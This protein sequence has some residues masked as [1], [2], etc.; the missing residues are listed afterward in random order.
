MAVKDFGK[1]KFATIPP[2]VM[3]IIDVN[4]PHC[5]KCFR[6]VTRWFTIWRVDLACYLR[7][8]LGECWDAEQVRSVFVEEDYDNAEPVKWTTVT[9][10]GNG[11]ILHVPLPLGGH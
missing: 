5:A 8:C 2:R 9:L 1:V 3:S 10:D 6:N 11:N 7:F 4:G